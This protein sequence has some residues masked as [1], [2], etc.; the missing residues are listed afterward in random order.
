MTNKLHIKWTFDEHDCETC[1]WI[2]GE[3][4]TVTLNDEVIYEI[5]A[6]GGCC[7]FTCV[8]REEVYKFIL[9]KLGVEIA[10]E[11]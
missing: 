11:F 7:S 8:D 3:G 4:V 5:E 6:N 2:T 1:G 9:N 10:D